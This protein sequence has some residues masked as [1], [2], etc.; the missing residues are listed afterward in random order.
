MQEGKNEKTQSKQVVYHAELPRKRGKLTLNLR[1]N[2]SKPFIT[3]TVL[4]MINSG[5]NFIQ[6]RE[7]GLVIFPEELPG[8]INILVEI[9]NILQDTFCKTL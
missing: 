2:G 5:D 1:R 7:A 3:M 4:S 9:Q 8:V 6:K